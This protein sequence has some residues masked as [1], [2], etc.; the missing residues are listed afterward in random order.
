MSDVSTISFQGKEVLVGSSGSLLL[1]CDNSECGTDH[2]RRIEYL[3]G[4]PDDPLKWEYC[5]MCRN[6]LQV[7]TVEDLPKWKKFWEKIDGL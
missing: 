4:P 6:K 1:G 2:F 5:V 7:I 3:A